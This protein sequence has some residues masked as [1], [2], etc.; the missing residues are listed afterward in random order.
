MCLALQTMS[1][2]CFRMQRF[3]RVLLQHV[4][5][6]YRDVLAQLSADD[7]GPVYLVPYL[8]FTGI[9]MKEIESEAAQARKRLKDVQVC[10]YIGFHPHVKSAYI[11]R[12]QETILNKDDAFRFRGEI[13]ASSP[14]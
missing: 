1:E 9:L 5:P 12:V 3:F 8:L 4:R 6:N 11:E 2:I 10:R 14:S 7:D 13:H